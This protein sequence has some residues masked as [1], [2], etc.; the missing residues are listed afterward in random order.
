MNLTYIF[1]FL[2]E[3]GEQ[4]RERLGRRGKMG[5]RRERGWGGEARWGTRER[6]WGVTRSYKEKQ[7]TTDLLTLTK[8]VCDD[9]YCEQ[10]VLS[11]CIPCSWTT[12][13]IL[14]C[15]EQNHSRMNKSNRRFVLK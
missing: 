2:M 9:E 13:T 1:R 8:T 4:K 11:P 3:D 6:G 10:D 7:T 14:T 15:I 12:T 5:N